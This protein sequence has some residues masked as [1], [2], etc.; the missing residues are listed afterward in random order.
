MFLGIYFHNIFKNHVFHIY[1]ICIKINIEYIYKTKLLY[2]VL[3]TSYFETVIICEVNKQINRSV[4]F[5]L[6][7]LC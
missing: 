2:N 5:T 7:Y 3:Y 1:K 6:L 4:F